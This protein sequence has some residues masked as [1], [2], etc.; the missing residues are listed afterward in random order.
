MRPG[1]GG[2]RVGY[3][4]CGVTAERP[5]RHDSGRPNRNRMGMGRFCSTFRCVTCLAGLLNASAFAAPRTA[6]AP[7]SSMPGPARPGT[8]G[9]AKVDGKA[10][11]KVEQRQAKWLT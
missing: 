9:A 8:H 10:E 3:D 11:G 2:L 4:A 6:A 1:A 7:S 5:R